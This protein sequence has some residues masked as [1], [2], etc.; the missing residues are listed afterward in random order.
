MITG[1]MNRMIVIGDI[2]GC[3]HTLMDLLEKVNYNKN[4]DTLIFLGDYIDRG[5]YSFEVVN[6]LIN[7]QKEVGKDKCICLMGNHE[8]MSFGMDDNL[9]NLNGGKKTKKSYYRHNTNVRIH[10]WWFKKLPLFYETDKFIFCHAGLTYPN[11]KDNDLD[12]LIWG[13]EWIEYKTV[14]NEKQVVFGH[15]PYN[16]PN[17]YK[18]NDG[19]ICI[20]S[21]CVFDGNLCAM[22]ILN[23]KYEFVYSYKSDLD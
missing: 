21:G 5:K 9:W 22:I 10:K 12:D 4:T 7:L 11:L 3:Y 19:S 1:N 16:N 23:D 15:T 13:R 17:I 20:D 6:Y 8:Y 2:H 14:P 18:T